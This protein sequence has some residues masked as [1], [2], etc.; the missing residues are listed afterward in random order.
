M[1]PPILTTAPVP[2]E[3]KQRYGM[4]LPPPCFTG[5]LLSLSFPIFSQKVLPC[6][7]ETPAHF[8]A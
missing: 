7:R 2:A 3:E 5:G 8:S 1:V 6:S 4:M